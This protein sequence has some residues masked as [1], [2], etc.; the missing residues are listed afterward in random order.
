MERIL[1]Q[2]SWIQVPYGSKCDSKKDCE[3]HHL[4]RAFVYFSHGSFQKILRQ[5]HVGVQK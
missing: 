3:S 4:T 1:A 5:D 2:M